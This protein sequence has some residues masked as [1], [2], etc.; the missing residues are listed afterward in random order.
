MN[1][2]TMIGQMMKNGGNPQQIF[3]QMMG[4]PNIANNPIAKNVFDMA[5]NG[6]ISGIEQFGRNMAKE[7]RN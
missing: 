4:D 2:L 3:Q 5:K 6:N 7:S 1:P